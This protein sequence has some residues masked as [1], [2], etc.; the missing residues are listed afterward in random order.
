MSLEL[1]KSHRASGKVKRWHT[2]WTVKEQTISDHVYNMIRIYYHIFG[3][4]KAE[5]FERLILHDVEERTFGDWPHWE[6]EGT[7][8]AKAKHEL[9]VQTRR[10]LGIP[11]Y[12]GFPTSRI[13][14]CDWIEA[15]EFMADEVLLGNHTLRFKLERLHDKFVKYIEEADSI[16]KMRIQSYLDDSG[17]FDHYNLIIDGVHRG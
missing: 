9:E 16:T 4:P 14:V 7:I 11:D 2:E 8:A 1:T 5:D 6:A 15:M 12:V 3:V 13:R 10:M 17:F